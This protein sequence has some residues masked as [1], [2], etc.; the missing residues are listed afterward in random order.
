MKKRNFNKIS[1]SIFFLGSISIL[2][3]CNGGGGGSSS[4]AISYPANPTNTLP[5]GYQCLPSGYQ[6]VQSAGSGTK[7]AY[8]GNCQVSDVSDPSQQQTL[9]S[10]AVALTNSVGKRYCTGTPI[11]FETQG[12]VRVGYVL[13]AAHCVT[14]NPKAAN[15]E[16]TTDNI[17]TFPYFNYIN[18]VL[19]ASSL[20]GTTGTIEAVYVLKQYCQAPSMNFSS[21]TGKYTCSDLPSQNGDVALLKVSLSPNQTLNYNPQV[22]L[23]SNAVQPDSPSYIMALGYGYTNTSSDNTN[24]FYITYEYF[25]TNSYQGTTGQSAIM[26]GYSLYGSS[27][28]YSIICS[29]DSGG[30]DFYWTNNKWNLIGV[31]SFGSSQ[32]G[33]GSPYYPQAMDASADVRPFA[34]IFQEI[35]DNPANYNSETGCGTYPTNK[36]VCKSRI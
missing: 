27:T 24:L 33:A 19:D 13:T 5:N 9:Q 28:F 32:C 6:A 1:L 2:S 30:G 29:G 17:V 14:G 12:N 3:A 23:A 16:I 21:Q 26:N 18:Q 15:Q 22:Q 25:A 35:I 34:T 10:M 8:G 36:L 11:K 4:P 31:H 20:S 7:I